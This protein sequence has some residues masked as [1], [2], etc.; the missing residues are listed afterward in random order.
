M[1]ESA[2]VLMG[3]YPRLGRVKTR[4]ASL[5]P[6]ARLLRL[7]E[8]LLDD[9]LVRFAGLAHRHYCFL[10][11]CSPAEL[12]N[13]SRRSATAGWTVGHQQGPDL[14]ARMWAASQQARRHA[15]RV[16]LIGCD[17]PTLP[18]NHVRQ[19]FQWLSEVPVVVGPVADGGYCL[20]GLAATLP[21]LFE[22]ID[23]GTEN[24]L[25]QTLARLAPGQ[26]KLLPSWYD[27]DRPQD[28]AMVKQDLLTT[29]EV[30]PSRLAELIRRWR[31]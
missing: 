21:Q 1:N 26:Y 20:L 12:A 31:L 4:L 3:R 5:L 15:R 10:A 6:P 19:G 2:L 25:A 22:G 30:Y 18:L 9:S 24:V 17:S 29:R 14:G 23:W 7:Y 16:I 28:L 11:D 8:A 27:L 13:W